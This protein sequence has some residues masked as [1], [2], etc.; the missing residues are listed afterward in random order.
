MKVFY[1]TNVLFFTCVE[2]PFCFSKLL[3]VAI[4]TQYAIYRALTFKRV[5]RIFSISKF[6]ANCS[7]RF[8][9]ALF[10]QDIKSVDKGYQGRRDTHVM[11]DYLLVSDARLLMEQ[12]HRQK[13]HK[14]TFLQ[15]VQVNQTKKFCYIFELLKPLSDVVWR[16]KNVYLL[17]K[18]SIFV[19]SHFLELAQHLCEGF[20]LR[21]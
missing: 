20:A 6:V 2:W 8:K 11:V 16:M 5:D 3:L 12:D 4:T 15:W 13:S 17:F 21:N 10:R 9:N 1:I 7:H 18:L 19:S 14:S